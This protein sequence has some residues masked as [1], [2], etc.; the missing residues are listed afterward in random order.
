VEVPAAA[1]SPL[2]VVEIPPEGPATI[3]GIPLPDALVEQLRA[4]AMIEPVAVDAHG[5]PRAVGKRSAVVSPKLARAVRLRDGHCRIPG[6][7]HRH[8]LQIHHLQ[9]RSWGGSD[10][11]SNLA[12]VCRG[13][14]HQMLVPHG[15]WVLVGNPNQPDGLRLKR[16]D[17]LTADERA[18]LGL[19]AK[20]AG[21]T[22]A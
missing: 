12:A 4:Q 10:D 8:G 1:P 3:A 14:H 17:E 18:Q 5:V 6:C 13:A 11:I 19:P 9:P 7:E 20:R 2:V 16:I 22:A 21:P 15:P